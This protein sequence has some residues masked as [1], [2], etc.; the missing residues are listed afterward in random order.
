MTQPTSNKTAQV[1]GLM[2]EYFSLT[3]KRA[4]IKSERSAY[5]TE[6]GVCEIVDQYGGTCVDNLRQGA[7]VTLCQIC[8][9]RHDWY[10]KLQ[11][12]GHRRGSI[13]SM[14]KRRVVLVIDDNG[15]WRK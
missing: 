9:K 11:V 4:K 3:K 8:E 6:N 15:A 1:A 13:M 12:I 2:Y 10:S 7:K 14:V 5:L